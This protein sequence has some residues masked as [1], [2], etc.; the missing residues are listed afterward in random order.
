MTYAH[1]AMRLG[2]VKRLR[3]CMHL[4]TYQ[5][6]QRLHPLT[7][8]RLTNGFGI[9]HVA[10]SSE[11]RIKWL[12]EVFQAHMRGDL[13]QAQ[14][15]KALNGASR[16]VR[17]E[18]YGLALT[19]LGATD[20]ERP[21]RYVDWFKLLDASIDETWL[22]QD[23]W[24][25][26]RQ[27]HMHALRKTGKSLLTQWMAAN[28]ALGR[29]PFTGMTQEAKRVLFLDPESTTAD[30]RSRLMDDMGF[31]PYELANLFYGLH[32][33]MAKLDTPEGGQ[34]L[35]NW[36]KEDDIQV[37]CID[38]FPRMV[39]GE[40]NS[41]DTYRNFYMHTGYR[42][43][44]ANVPYIRTDNEGHH[45]GRSRGSSAKAD[46]VDIVWGLKEGQDGLELV[47][48]ASRIAD[49]PDKVALYKHEEPLRFERGMQMWPAGTKEKALE[50]EAINAPLDISR[51]AASQLFKEAGLPVGKSAV[52]QAALN[53][54]KSLGGLP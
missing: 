2:N 46:D 9:T 53:Y 45:E 39:Q 54:R 50:L 22:V 7:Y 24:P 3:E 44:A 33:P 18:E 36:V 1:G 14:T 52:L 28:L 47:R 10:T 40:E 41:A 31:K 4:R 16:Y 42:L 19:E 49:V 43:K 15:L 51:R 26:G 29:D 5:G 11:E 48:K 27:I 6:L 13:D 20:D 32:P 30:I 34:T 8:P 17:P 21:A 37:V 35:M 23:V 38:G 25:M 12:K